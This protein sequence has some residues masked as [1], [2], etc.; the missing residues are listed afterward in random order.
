MRVLIRGKGGV[1]ALGCSLSNG[2]GVWCDRQGKRRVEGKRVSRAEPGI[3]NRMLIT[4]EQDHR[5]SPSF[6]P[7]TF[8]DCLLCARDCA[9]GSLACHLVTS[10]SLLNVSISPC[11]LGA[12]RELTGVSSGL[13][14]FCGKD[15][16]HM[17]LLLQ[18]SVFGNEQSCIV[19]QTPR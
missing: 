3:A 1:S 18:C 2:D 7:H 12:L 14:E 16:M 13:P 19:M 11:L 10:T 6:I 8:T 5:A 15:K 9:L 4:P 17:L